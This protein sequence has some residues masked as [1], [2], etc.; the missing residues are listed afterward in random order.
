[1]IL[2]V[3]IEQDERIELKTLL[4]NQRIRHNRYLTEGERAAFDP[5][6]PVIQ[7]QCI[8][9]RVADKILKKLDEV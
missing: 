2:R 5:K 8:T 7:C 1:M 3:E 9:C 4:C 6:S